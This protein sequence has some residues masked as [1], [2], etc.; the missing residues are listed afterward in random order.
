MPYRTRGSRISETRQVPDKRVDEATHRPRRTPAGG[1]VRSQVAHI[2]CDL[3]G[4]LG[5]PQYGQSRSFIRTSTAVA[6]L[7]RP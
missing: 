4:S 5:E 7:A 6:S 3:H 1:A 2:G